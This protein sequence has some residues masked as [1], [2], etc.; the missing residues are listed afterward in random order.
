MVLP[1]PCMEGT[2]FGIP[3]VFIVVTVCLANLLIWNIASFGG[4]TNSYSHHEGNRGDLDGGLDTRVGTWFVTS[5]PQSIYPY[6]TSLLP[7]PGSA[8]LPNNLTNPFLEG[9][10]V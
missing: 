8:R 5:S 7:E 3:Y 1:I 10:T 6:E 9:K 2:R 4:N